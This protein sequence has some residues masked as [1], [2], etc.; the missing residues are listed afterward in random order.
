MVKIDE[1]AKSLGFMVKRTC[2]FNAFY[3]LVDENGLDKRNAKGETLCVEIGFCYNN[4]KSPKSLPVIWYKKGYT[5]EIITEWW[6]VDTFV[7]D[8]KGNCY[9]DYDPTIKR[10]WLYSRTEIDFDWHLPATDENFKKIL[11]EILRRFN[12]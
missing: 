3:Y 12:A 5:K 6:N 11:E 4:S 9:R 1:I 8:I 10:N 2:E 7:T